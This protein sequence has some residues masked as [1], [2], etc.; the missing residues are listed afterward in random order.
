MKARLSHRLRAAG[1]WARSIPVTWTIVGLVLAATIVRLSLHAGRMTAQL[2]TLVSTGFDTVFLR[3]DWFSL[4][5]SVFFV[6]TPGLLVVVAIVAVLCLGW[7]ERRLGHWRTVVAFVVVSVLGIVLGL[8]LDSLGVA[9]HLYPAEQSRGTRT[10]DPIIAV[11]GVVMTATAF[12]GPVLRRR[13]RVIGFVSLLTFVLYSGQQSD[14]FRLLAAAVGLL[15][16]MLLADRR[17]TLRIP[18]STHREAR[19]I[20][21]AVVAITGLG[22]LITLAAPDSTSLLNPLGQLFRDPLRDYQRV[23][24]HCATGDFSRKCVDALALS[25]LDGPGAVALSFLP[26]VALVLAAWGIR[27]GRRMALWLAVGIN[28]MLT[29][30][31]AVY[32]GFF[33]LVAP[34]ETTVFQTSAVEHYGVFVVVSVL[35][36][37]AVA[38]ALV[39]SLRLFPREAGV[40]TALRF[41]AVAAGLFVV[42]ASA[43]VSLSLVFRHQ[44]SPT[45][46][47]SSLLLDL[48]ER[49]IPASFLSFEPV[50]VFPTGPVAIAMYQWVGTVYWVAVMVL[51]VISMRRVR[52]V[53][54]SSGPA[55]IR[56]LVKSGAGGD[57][58]W[59]ATWTGNEYWFA[60]D[61][62]AVAYRVEGNVAITTAEPL[63]PAGR[64]HAVALEFERF[65]IEHGWTCAFYSVSDALRS[66]LAA[67]GWE[68]MRVAEETV[69]RPGEFT[70]EGKRMQDIR[71]SINRAAREGVHDVWTTYPA[72]TPDLAAQVREISE[73]WV[74]EKGLPEMGF[75]LGGIDELADPEVALML[76]VDDDGR[77]QG[78]TSWLP[79]FRDGRRIGLTLDF[80]RRH[81][82]SIN[83]VMEFLIAETIQRATQEDIEF[84]SLSAAP[85]AVASGPETAQGAAP[86]EAPSGA[87]AAFL[88]FVARALEP[89]Y[90]FRSLLR[91]KMKFRPELRELALCYRDPITLPS[92][93]AAIA[94]AYLPTLSARH[95][96]RLLG[97]MQRQ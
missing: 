37:L 67:D 81:P 31:A 45:A 56:E 65:C 50:D 75:T 70:L 83:G 79:T 88:A 76:A 7:S 47:L 62:S 1:R 44:F 73:L 6:R 78:V 58:A 14:I 27:H 29:L 97:Q 20:L 57:L 74:A 90:G 92:I 60:A 32:Y 87:T 15:L 72:L 96:V 84:V 10:L 21:A 46:S 8:L 68:S 33:P 85:L 35:F 93:G 42:V 43:Y 4:L 91:F 23:A 13:I 66:E 54:E 55:R 11:V 25:R 36:P 40:R 41:F 52:L 69:V 80:M 82:D 38:I 19:T 64:Q 2:D 39:A 48:P 51:A 34:T 24:E 71:T 61:G 3:H 77:V 9:V 59:M 28:V 17:V 86:S 22:P 5:S 12:T 16:G 30:L 94:R 53:R 26:L 18:R 63:A 95:A 49:F 89:V